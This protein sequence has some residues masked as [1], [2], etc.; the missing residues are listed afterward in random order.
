[1]V[2]GESFKP[3]SPRP[4]PVGEIVPQKEM[5]IGSN[6]Y[7]E[8]ETFAIKY[9]FSF[10]AACCSET[11]TYPLDL[12]KGR[13]QIQGESALEALGGGKA[14]PKRG[15]VGT[16]FGIVYSGVRMTFYEYI[17]EEL[18]GKN[19]DG[20]IP[21]WKAVLGGCVAGMTAQ[22]L[23]SPAD[24]VKVQVQME[25]R[26]RLQGLE[27][28]V[29][30]A[31]HAFARIYMEGGV[32]GLWKGWMPNVQRAAF[33]NLGDLATYDT[34]KHLILKHTNLNDNF[35]THAF[36]SVFSG[37]VA[38]LLGTPADV[39]KTRVMNQPTDANGRG[40]LYKS[41]MDC[42]LQAIRG[43]G[44]FSLYKGF[45]PCWIRMGPWS[46]IFWISYEELRTFSGVTSF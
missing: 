37:F 44:F 17:R 15:M 9:T 23:A 21:V 31:R 41:S 22:F 5:T 19:A 13:L 2:L 11:I 33:V 35:F 7:N 4:K 20:T 3:S 32:R 16:A 27:P 10:L 1:M 24:L 40:L 45:I 26:R 6:G 38:A 12:I 43:E 46:L 18:L 28:R 29:R 34:A 25:G 30:N 14:L 8:Y 39:V 36:S 42:L